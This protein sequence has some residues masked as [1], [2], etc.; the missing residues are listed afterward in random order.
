M[1]ADRF[2]GLAIVG[3]RDLLLVTVS[4]DFHDQL[5]VRLKASLS[6]RVRTSGSRAVVLDISAVE[7]ID[8]Y[9]TR[10]LNDI[11]SCVRFMGAGCFVV[12]MRPAVAM[13]LVEMGIHLEGIRTA[14]SLDEA[15]TALEAAR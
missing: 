14:L 15:V 5:A 10:V 4:S 11:G 7:V 9:I 3:I 12:G 13:T 2:D 1:G 8:S 6:D